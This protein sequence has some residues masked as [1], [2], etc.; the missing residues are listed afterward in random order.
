MKFSG[1]LPLLPALVSGR[2][3]AL[4]GP[5]VTYEGHKVYRVTTPEG[6]SAME[7]RLAGLSVTMM[8]DH[9]PETWVD[10]V[11]SPEAHAEFEAMGLETE[12]LHE[13][14]ARDIA[15]EAAYKPY[16]SKLAL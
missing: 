9:H 4:R 7:E 14:L 13:D 12:V 16:N 2:R 6:T 3:L 10:V 1:V 5:R 15:A 8:E 11:V